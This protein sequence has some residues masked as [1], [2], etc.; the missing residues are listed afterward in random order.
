M[1]DLN[2]FVSVHVGVRAVSVV[3]GTGDAEVDVGRVLAGEHHIA[4]H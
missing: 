2:Y 1:R 3:L 4:L